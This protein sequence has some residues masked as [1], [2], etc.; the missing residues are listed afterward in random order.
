MNAPA[1]PVSSQTNQTHKPARQTAASGSE[2]TET[3][4]SPFVVTI[5]S[6]GS[7]FPNE[8]T[9]APGSSF[10]VTNN[11]TAAAVIWDEGSASLIVRPGG[12]S[13]PITCEASHTYDITILMP[14]STPQ[15]VNSKINVG[16]GDPTPAK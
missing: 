13:G 8:V 15:F 14:D 16:S 2:S 11:F 3:E 10:T 4:L 12:S 9:L 7:I 1:F 5:N 6:D